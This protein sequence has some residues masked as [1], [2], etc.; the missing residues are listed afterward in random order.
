MSDQ[1]QQPAKTEAEEIEPDE[2]EH[3]AGIA[4]TFQ[5]IEQDPADGQAG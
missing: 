4:K 1:V 5:E 3:C 2:D